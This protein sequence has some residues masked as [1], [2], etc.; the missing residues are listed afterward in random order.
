MALCRGLTLVQF[1][2]YFHPPF[3]LGGGGIFYS[4]EHLSHEEQMRFPEM[5]R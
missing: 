4:L 1:S 3:F 5:E 2:Y